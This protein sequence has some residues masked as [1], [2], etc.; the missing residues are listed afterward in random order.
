MAKG[1]EIKGFAGIFAGQKGL[2]DIAG[3]IREG[4]IRF[5]ESIVDG[6]EAA[7]ATFASVFSGHTH[8]GKLLIKVSDPG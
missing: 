2:D 7:P 1:L 8:L 4:K 6:I 3:W 5:P